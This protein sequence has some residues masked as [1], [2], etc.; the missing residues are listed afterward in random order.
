MN[1]LREIGEVPGMLEELGEIFDNAIDLLTPNAIVYGGALRDII[2]GMEIKG[3]LDIAVS[4]HESGTLIN[5]FS[6]DA[7]WIEP[8]TCLR[9]SDIIR[10]G[11]MPDAAPRRTSPS[12]KWS[13]PRTLSSN[14]DGLAP[15]ESVKD[16][17]TIGGV[18]A[19]IIVSDRHDLD[20]MESVLEVVRNVDIICCGLFMMFDGRLFEAVKDAE[21]DC[22]KRVLRINYDSCNLTNVDRTKA[23]LEHLKVRG[24]KVSVNMK[25]LNRKTTKNRKAAERKKKSEMERLFGPKSRPREPIMDWEEGTPYLHVRKGIIRDLGGLDRTKHA[26][27]SKLSNANISNNIRTHHGAL[28]VEVPTNSV[29]DVHKYLERELEKRVQSIR[30]RKAIRD[31][32]NAPSMATAYVPSYNAKGRSKIKIKSSPNKL[33]TGMFH[34]GPAE[35]LMASQ[36]SS[37]NKRVHEARN[38][39]EHLATE[40]DFNV[41]TEARMDGSIRVIVH[42]DNLEEFQAN[43]LEAFRMAKKIRRKGGP[44]SAGMIDAVTEDVLNP[45]PIVAKPSRSKPHKVVEVIREEPEIPV[46]FE[47]SEAI[48]PPS[49]SGG[50]MWAQWHDS[51]EVLPDPEML[52]Q[53]QEHEA[54]PG[55]QLNPVKVD[56]EGLGDRTV[57]NASV[58]LD[59]DQVWMSVDLDDGNTIKKRLDSNEVKVLSQNLFELN[60]GSIPEIKINI[61]EVE[62]KTDK[63]KKSMSSGN[64]SF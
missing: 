62:L 55:P 35:V 2:A 14:Y 34:V 29:H 57:I 21:K 19:Q 20:P 10:Q 27:A 24:W 8:Q 41:Q 39:I 50:N 60:D 33:K 32:A 13:T 31:K 64:D 43:V 15:I 54:S 42:P 59:G 40:M 12:A 37:S 44:L 45:Q 47:P 46:G 5:T 61:H 56:F 63:H 25:E 58:G 38:L 17:R 53:V 30:T 7:K 18:K 6:R 22:Q 36:S 23:R 26:I 4:P 52:K 3:D 9:P 51:N 11:H 48:D 16:F 49:D 28:R 1:Y